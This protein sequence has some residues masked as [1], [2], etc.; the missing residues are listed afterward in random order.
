M[1]SKHDR[2]LHGHH[3]RNQRRI[4]QLWDH[5]DDPPRIQ[6]MCHL[7]TQWCTEYRSLVGTDLPEIGSPHIHL[8]GNWFEEWV[9]WSSQDPDHME[10][11]ESCLSRLRFHRTDP[12]DSIE[13]SC[14]RR[15]CHHKHLRERRTG[16]ECTEMKHLQRRESASGTACAAT[17][18]QATKQRNSLSGTTMVEHCEPATRKMRPRW[19]RSLLEG[20]PGDQAVRQAQH[21]PTEGRI[22]VS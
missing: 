20:L 10:D 19:T 2:A 13:N 6:R 11:Q 22:A 5:T 7:H 12:L 17:S 15:D 3:S 4:A 1:T 9:G 8:P 14:D 18:R 16:T 21:Q